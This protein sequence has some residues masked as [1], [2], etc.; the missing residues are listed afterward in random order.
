MLLTVLLEDI[1]KRTAAERHSEMH[2]ATRVVWVS[3][4]IT[5]STPKGG[6]QLDDRGAPKQLK[7]MGNYMQSKAGN[8]F[9]AK[10]FADRWRGS[11]IVSVVRTPRF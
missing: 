6:V 1:I 9:L 3:S 10:E 11:D 4:S 2:A 8:T 7:S 5:L